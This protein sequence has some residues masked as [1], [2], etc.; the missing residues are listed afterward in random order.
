[1]NHPD[2]DA[3]P[4]PNERTASPAVAKVGCLIASC[5]ALLPLLYV[6]SFAV[7]LADSRYKGPILRSLDR[8]VLLGLELFYWPLIVLREAFL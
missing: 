6:G 1:M 3:P 7:L 4:L 5:S 8:R 2:A